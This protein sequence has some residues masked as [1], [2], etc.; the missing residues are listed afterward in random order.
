MARRTNVILG[1]GVIA[2]I[3]TVLVWLYLERGV[4]VT[5]RNS[6]ARA[7]RSVSVHVTGRAYV[8]GDLEPGAT[9]S[10]RVNPTGESSVEIR[11]RDD[12]G[13]TKS[14][15][16]GGYIE[17]GYAG[18]MEVDVDFERVRKAECSAHPWP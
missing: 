12:S 7:L 13:K 4:L 1:A 5:V 18:S 16:A 3:A 6:D 14:L 9:R 10:V 2:C 15:D 17:A 8:L 11:F